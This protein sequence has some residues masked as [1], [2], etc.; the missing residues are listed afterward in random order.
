MKGSAFISLVLFLM[1]FVYNT[2]G[3]S[4]I[5]AWNVVYFSILSVYIAIL[6]IGLYNNC[7][8][9][10]YSF[11]FLLSAVYWFSFALAE[12]VTLATGHYFEIIRNTNL[13]LSRSM[14]VFAGLILFHF[15][16]F[17]K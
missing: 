5:P 17:K 1:L 14:I 2:W 15:K 8:V 6:N 7:V 16:F 11:I 10:K 13:W 4:S 9:K 3:D 12:L